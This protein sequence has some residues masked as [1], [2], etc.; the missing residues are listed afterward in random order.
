MT[1]T[2]FTL[3][4]NMHFHLIGI[5]GAGISAIARVLLGRGF[6]VSGSDREA[7]AFTAVLQSEGATIY[8]GHQAANIVGADA[9]VISSA[10]PADNPEVVAAKAARIPV[11]KRA[12]L[13]GH[14][15]ADKVGI[16]IAGSHGKTTTTGMITQIFMSADLDPTV[17]VGGVLPVLG[18]NGRYGQGNHFIIEADEYD[19]MFLGLRPTLAIVTSVEHDHPDIFPTEADYLRAFADFAKLL[20]KNGRL[21]ACNEEAGVQQLLAEVTVPVTTYGLG[22]TADFRATDLRP[23]QLGGTDFLILKGRDTVGLIRLRVPGEHN[24]KNALAAIIIALQE[25]IPFATMQRALA[26]FGGVGRRFQVTGEVGGVTVIDDYGHHPT[27]IRTTLAAARQRFPGRRV[28][29]VWQPHTYSRTKLLLTEFAAS[30][31]DAD[32]VIALDIYASREKETLGMN[33]AVVIAAMNHPQAIHIPCRKDAAAYLLDRVQ[34][35]D[36]ILLFSAGDGNMVGQW[37]LEGLQK[38]MS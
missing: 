9:L 15:M 19:Y 21:V 13:L 38:R 7:N 35:G 30:F 37:V 3:K 24:V 22:E 16:A 10:I 1:E 32:R 18:S 28:W 12:D 6:E 14:L 33:T 27:A 29:A 2:T 20:P 34:P 17:I 4:P 23:N 5:G 11:L 26:E 8:E 31:A 36:V 25:G